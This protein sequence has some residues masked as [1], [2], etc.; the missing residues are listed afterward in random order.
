MGK[1]GVRLKRVTQFILVVLFML[2]LSGCVVVACQ[3]ALL[4]NPDYERWK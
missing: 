2:P 1:D 3:M 4:S